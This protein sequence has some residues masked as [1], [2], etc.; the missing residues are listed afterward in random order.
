MLH[1]AK[2]THYLFNVKKIDTQSAKTIHYV[3]EQQA[4]MNKKFL[5]QTM[6]KL[7]SEV[8]NASG[9]F[10]YFYQYHSKALKHYT[11]IHV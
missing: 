4:Y 3:T 1:R 11:Y 5:Y 7:F 6:L 10:L 2:I 8:F 9:F